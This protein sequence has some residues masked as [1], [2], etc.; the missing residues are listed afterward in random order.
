MR[1]C[2]KCKEEFP[3]ENFPEYKGKTGRRL[4]R[5][6]CKKCHNKAHLKRVYGGEDQRE[7]KKIRDKEWRQ[8]NPEKAKSY[9]ENQK[10]NQKKCTNKY[11]DRLT[12][13]YIRNRLGI[14]P[15]YKV[16]KD[17]IEC[18]RLQIKIIRLLWEKI[19]ERR[20]RR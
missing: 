17:L 8:A 3:L 14:K 12:E 4:R 18:K 13:A 6:T 9:R 10:D 19:H 2:K 11:R 7:K 5:W 1:V 15:G 20:E 16:S